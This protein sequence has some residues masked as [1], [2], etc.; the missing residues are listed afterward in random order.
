MFELAHMTYYIE[1]NMFNA[2]AMMCESEVPYWF[3]EAPIF[4]VMLRLWG[5]SMD[6][7]VTLRLYDETASAE[8]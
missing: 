1:G 2:T 4:Q 5:S 3:T 8:Y 6:P 7:W